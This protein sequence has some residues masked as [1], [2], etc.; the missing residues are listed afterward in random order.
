MHAERV[1]SD[2]PVLQTGGNERVENVQTSPA[3]ATSTRPS[4]SHH[5]VIE[6]DVLTALGV[7]LPKTAKILDFGCGAGRTI[8]ALRAR[9]YANSY[10]YDVGDGRNLLGDQCVS[11]HCLASLSRRDLA[12]SVRCAPARKR[13]VR[14]VTRSAYAEVLSCNSRN[15]R[16]LTESEPLRHRMYQPTRPS[17]RLFA[18]LNRVGMN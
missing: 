2:N 18:V 4:D 10:G 9:G 16:S 8:R 11:L 13:T 1:T 6:L 12:G 17:G 3:A 7:E 15:A 5:R 14:S